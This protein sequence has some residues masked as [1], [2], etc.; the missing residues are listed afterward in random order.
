MRTLHSARARGVHTAQAF[1]WLHYLDEGVRAL[2]PTS[3]AY[4]ATGAHKPRPKEWSE[5]AP[6]QR[7]RRVSPAARA[8]FQKDVRVGSAPAAA[9]FGGQVSAGRGTS[10]RFAGKP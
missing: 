4:D 3:A 8:N 10:G 7:P 1:G 9:V 6:P 2:L 5:R